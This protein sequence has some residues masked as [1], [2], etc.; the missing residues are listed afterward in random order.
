MN[1]GEAAAHSGLPPRTIRYYEEVE[2]IPAPARN[3]AGYRAYTGRDV[4]LLR[5]IHAAR[6]L[7]FTVAECRELV[8]LYRDPVR[9]AADVKAVALRKLDR[10]DRK[11]AELTAMRTALA[12]LAEKCHGTDRPDC[13]ILD[14]LAGHTSTDMAEGN[15][16]DPRT[17][18]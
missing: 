5:F 2:L 17:H 10:I 4:H 12:E 9:A 16:S 6:G 11:I 3:G 8:S 1:I 14:T 18:G 15:F 13:P 7:G